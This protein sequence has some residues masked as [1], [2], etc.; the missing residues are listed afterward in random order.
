MG[1]KYTFFNL[2]ILFGVFQGF[3]LLVL[4]NTTRSSKRNLFLSL[5]VFSFTIN[6]LK[7]MLFDLGLFQLYPE[8]T[9]IPFFFFL[10]GPSLYCYVLLLTGQKITFK[11]HRIHFYPIV[12]NF[13]Y[14][15]ISYFIR[16]ENIYEFH[17]NTY[18]VIEEFLSLISVGTYLVLTLKKLNMYHISIQNV[19]SEFTDNTLQW[20]KNLCIAYFIGWFIWFLFYIADLSFDYFYNFSGAEAYYPLYIYMSI[21]IYWIGYSGYTKSEFKPIKN[22]KI[23][24]VNN[25]SEKDYFSLE[26]IVSIMEEQKLFVNPTLRIDELAEHC[27]MH[28]KYISFLLN[29]GMNKTFYDYVNSL[30]IEEFKSK[31]RDPENN[32]YTIQSLAEESGFRSRSTFNDLFKKFEQ[33]TPKQYKDT[34]Q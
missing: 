21:F 25:L 26:Q 16:N 12:M 18:R 32:Q 8:L 19:F 34:M 2:L 14:Y 24:E 13:L 22:D 3:T 9:F 15:G 6:T 30:R 27:G 10:I 33:M 29:K 11:T 31:L 7:M 4:L 17:T 5:M 28:S 23:N 1:L 20:L